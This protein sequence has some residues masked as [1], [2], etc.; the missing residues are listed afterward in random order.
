[1]GEDKQKWPFDAWLKIAVFRLGWTPNQFWDC[2][3][4]DWLC[5][6]RPVERQSLSRFDFEDLQTRFPDT[7]LKKDN[8]EHS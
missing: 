1:M 4:Q 8:D 3:V 6:I 7:D 5:L 2:S